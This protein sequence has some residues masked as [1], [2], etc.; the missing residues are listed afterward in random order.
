MT[1]TQPAGRFC[2]VQPSL[3]EHVHGLPIGAGIAA[4]QIALSVGQLDATA[5]RFRAWLRE[6]YGDVQTLGAAE[7][8][9]PITRR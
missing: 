5:V 2:L 3:D 9:Q 8:Q 6:K 1:L 4:D 7:A